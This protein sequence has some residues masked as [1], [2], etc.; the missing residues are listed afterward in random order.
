MKRMIY[1]FFLLLPI[2]LW[3]EGL[4]AQKTNRTID[5]LLVVLKTAKEDTTKVKTLN[6]L[7]RQ[8]NN[9]S[10]YDK[11]MKYADSAL[12]LANQLLNAETKEKTAVKQTARKEIANAYY[13]KAFIYN[14]KSNYSEAL[15]NS[16][17][18]L[19]IYEEIGDK[20][21]IG[22]CY[23]NKGNSYLG[24]SNYPDAMK[25]Y[26]AALRIGEEEKDKRMTFFL[27]PISVMFILIRT[28][29]RKR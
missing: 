15:N 21:G 27:T 22:K 16:L 10:D 19:K 25:C 8:Y 5:S 7:C 29:T 9:T 18:A 20:I 17:I 6:L 11:G 4:L 3:H 2:C 23:T 1:R 24:Q 12:D 26:L 28:I 14:I 13:Y